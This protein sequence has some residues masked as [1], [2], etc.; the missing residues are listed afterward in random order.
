[1]KSVRIVKFL[2]FPAV[3]FGLSGPVS[4]QTYTFKIGLDWNEASGECAPCDYNELER[5]FMAAKSVKIPVRGMYDFEVILG[6]IKYQTVQ[7]VTKIDKN[8]L[9]STATVELSTGLGRGE[10]FLIAS[11]TPLIHSG[12]ETRLVKEIEV[13]V[14]ATPDLSG[15]DRAATFAANSVL[16]SGNWY[17]IGVNTR[18]IYKIDATFLSSLGIA[19]GSLNP[20]HINVYGNHISELPSLNSAYHPDDLLKNAIFI[21]GDGDG[22]FDAADYILFYA[23]GPDETAVGPT[24]I[25]LSRN[26]IDSLAYFF[27]HIDASDPPKRITAISESS[28]PVTHTVTECNDAVLHEL[29]EVNLLK[30]GDGWLG[31]HFDIE[32]NH[33]FSAFL[34]QLSTEDTIIMKTQY[35]SNQE[36]PSSNLEVNVN[37]V[38][39]D[40]I[41]SGTVTGSY[42]EAVVMNSVEQFLS[43]SPTLNF[44][45]EYTRSNPSSQ[46]WLD[47]ILLNYRRNLNIG[48]NPF[49]IRSLE[50]VAVG[51]VCDYQISSAN[52]S[53]TVWEVTDRS[54]AKAVN[55]SLSGSIYSFAMNADSLRTFAVFSASQ[56]YAPVAIGSVSNQNLHGLPFADYLIVSHNSLTSQANRLANLHRAKGLAV[57]VVDIQDVYNEFSGGVS[58]PVAIRWFAKMFYD[59]A[60]GDPADMP[61]NLCLFGDGTYDPLNRLPENFYLIPTYNSPES[62]NIDYIA[63]FTADDFYGILDDSESINASDLMDIGVGRIPVSDLESATDVV[64]KIEHYMNYGST[65]YGN[66]EGIQC[67]S[68]TGYTSSFGDWRTRI[69]LVGDDED[70]GIFVGDCESLSD[71]VENKYPE[72]NIVKIYLDA[73]QQVVTSG[74]QRYPDVEEAINQN[75]NKGALTFQ[76]VGHGGETGLALER[77]VTIPQI[78]EWENVNHMTVFISATC[79]F[80]RFDDPAR[81]SAGEITL[82]TPYGGAVALLTTTRLVYI[83]VNTTIVRNLYSVLFLEEAGEPLALGEIMRRTKNLSAGSGNNIRNFS[84]LGDPA[85]QLGLPAPRIETDSING[86]SI[87]MATDTLKA[88]SK[89]TITGHIEDNSGALLSSYNGIVFPTVFD[90]VKIKSTLGQDPKSP[91]KDFDTQTN[92][93]YKGKATVKNGLFSFTFVVPKDIE[94]SF[95]KGKISYYSENGDYDNYGFD[96]S[97][98]VGGIDPNGVNDQTGPVMDLYL[99]DPN[100]ANGGMTDENPQFIAEINDENGIN[101]TG[102]GI[103]HDITLIIDGNT[104]DPIVLNNFY[105]ADLDTYQSGKVTYPLADLAEGEHTLTF[106]VWDVNNNSSEGRLNF[107]V[108]KETELGISHLLNYPNPFTTQTEFF[109]EHNQVCTALEAKLEIFTVS[110]KLVKSIVQTVTCSGYRSSGIPWDGRDDFG[111]KL[112]R[113]VYVYRLSLETPEGNKAEKLEKLVIL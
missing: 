61:E 92:V 90:K 2:L 52:S 34:D 111:D 44:S 83:S 104:A 8:A 78:E 60:A 99:N 49:V 113:G 112:A 39:E 69:V 35:A 89:V 54:N 30:S 100:F 25:T 86:V 58:D 62:G 47:Y 12:G 33:T 77:V 93:L 42:T 80:S 26:D 82:V 20:A 94:Y 37:G 22:S 102:N 7:N 41:P 31:E 17:K 50:T 79:E 103:G 109:F 70:N 59:R 29:D 56:A 108:V 73:Y 14:I 9:P 63:S 85:L 64:N 3:I 6:E 21:Q 76:Y 24:T 19:T 16:N 15:Q 88:L 96:T 32:L 98:V 95:G 23:E 87:S 106:K 51:N 72:L 11:Y 84:L 4:A 97:V 57:H 46:A 18:G 38:L 105:E 91:V 43:S 40:N 53:T 68:G 101:T 81:T 71:T 67:T 110:G 36:S 27:I 65:L 74:G 13:T 55:G 66:T 10:N 1:M 5:S 75:M 28:D 107:V 48:S 45:I